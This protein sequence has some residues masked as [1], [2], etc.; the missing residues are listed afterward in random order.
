MAALC[1]FGFPVGCPKRMLMAE[2]P[3][4]YCTYTVSINFK[5]ASYCRCPQLFW[6]KNFTSWGRT[7]SGGC[8]TSPRV[9][10]KIVA[11]RA[12]INVQPSV[13]IFE[14]VLVRTVG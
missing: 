10:G 13:L 14:Y 5:V 1:E 6:K 3:L 8:I 9:S 11:D 4:R 2:P 12:S 7:S